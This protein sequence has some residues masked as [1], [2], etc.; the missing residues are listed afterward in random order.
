MQRVCTRRWADFKSSIGRYSSALLLLAIASLLVACDSTVTSNQQARKASLAPSQC[1]NGP[2]PAV[3]AWDP[4][5]DPS[6]RYRVYYGTTS[7][8]YLQP[9]G[10]GLD[11]AAATSYTVTNLTS[12]TT[13]YFAV[14]AYDVSISANESNPSNEVCKK[15]P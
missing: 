12:G 5:S 11:A 9:A 1:A 13:Y 15:I 6:A 3:L 8:T 4:I 14:T 10:A 7:G 2:S